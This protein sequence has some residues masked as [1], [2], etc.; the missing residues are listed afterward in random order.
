MGGRGVM[1]TIDCLRVNASCTWMS[2]VSMERRLSCRLISTFTIAT[3]SSVSGE[4][5]CPHSF[6]WCVFRY[7]QQLYYNL[8]SLSLFLS[9]L[10]VHCQ[11]Y[12]EWLKVMTL[13]ERESEMRMDVNLLQFVALTWTDTYRINHCSWAHS[14]SHRVKGHWACERVISSPH[15]KVIGHRIY[16]IPPKGTNCK[17]RMKLLIKYTRERSFKQWSESTFPIIEESNLNINTRSAPHSSLVYN[18]RLSVINIH[19]MT[20][21]CSTVII[22]R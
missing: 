13:Q 10:N 9:R 6:H 11:R 12:L 16:S 19:C 2:L 7:T 14:L 4:K 21:F 8:I 18:W 17:W 20:F 3:G 22:S 5:C 1:Y 15:V